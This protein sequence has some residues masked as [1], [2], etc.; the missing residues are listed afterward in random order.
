MHNLENFTPSISGSR[1]LSHYQKKLLA[2]SIGFSCYS[3]LRR[4]MYAKC[5]VDRA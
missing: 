1:L 4:W 2:K 3:T 5:T